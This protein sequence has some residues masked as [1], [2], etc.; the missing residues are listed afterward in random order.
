MRLAK[1]AQALVKGSI[2]G[3][4]ALP[5]QF[6]CS[7]LGDDHKTTQ[8][9]LCSL[10]NHPNAGGVL[11]LGLGCENNNIDVFK[12]VIGEYSENRVKFCNCQDFDDE[13]FG[14]II[15]VANGAQ[16]QNELHGY[17]EI[18]IFKDGVTL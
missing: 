2:D 3:I 12:G 16:T 14:Y 11:V 7:Q 18:S 6:G 9:I 5:H 1:K 17:K 13:L 10:I 8:K 15:D 4:Y